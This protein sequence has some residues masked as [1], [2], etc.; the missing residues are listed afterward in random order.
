MHIVTLFLTSSF[1]SFQAYQRAI[2]LNPQ[3]AGLYYDMGVVCY[4]QSRATADPAASR[5]L[6]EKAARFVKVHFLKCNYHSYRLFD[7]NLFF[8]CECKV[9]FILII[10]CVCYVLLILIIDCVCYV[11]L[12]LIID[13]VCYVLLIIDY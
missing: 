8:F 3:C 2:H 6:T 4:H 5:K 9:L 12:I 10:D 1:S 13:C 7:G 11:L